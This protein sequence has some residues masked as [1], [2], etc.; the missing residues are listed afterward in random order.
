M[1]RTIFVLCSTASLI[2]LFVLAQPASGLA[3]APLLPVGTPDTPPAPAADVLVEQARL[4][5][6]ADRPVAA[7]R[8]LED[9]LL[10][11]TIDDV[12]R[13]RAYFLRGQIL[14]QQGKLERALLDYTDAIALQPTIAEVYAFRATVYFSLDDLES[15][16]QDYELALEYDNSQA[17][18]YLAAGIVQA[19]LEAF[20][21][22]QASFTTALELDDEFVVAY[23]ERGLAAL[24]DG[25]T[26]QARSDLQTYLDTAPDATDAAAIEEI[27]DELR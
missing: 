27:L 24:A 21:A 5:N 12:A 3:G 25:D 18:Y 8:L 26:D 10:L 22:A 16:L 9:A 23:R 4:L 2:L 1:Q 19:Q 7:L 11:G 17:A 6:N 20:T 13:F 14:Q 15:A